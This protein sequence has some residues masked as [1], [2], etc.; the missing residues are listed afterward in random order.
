[1]SF[2]FRDYISREVQPKFTKYYE[3]L[4]LM[5]NPVAAVW[6]QDVGCLVHGSQHTHNWAHP[7]LAWLE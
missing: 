4:I 2:V 3:G 7:S 6:Y 1:M 5:K